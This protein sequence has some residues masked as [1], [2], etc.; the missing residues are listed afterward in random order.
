MNNYYLAGHTLK[1]FAGNF[2][3]FY[4]GIKFSIWIWRDLSLYLGWSIILRYRCALVLVQ[5]VFWYNFGF[6]SCIVVVA[7]RDALLVIQRTFWALHFLPII[8]RSYLDPVTRPSNCGTRWECASTPF[9]C[10]VHGSVLYGLAPQYLVEDCELVAAADRHQLR[11]SNTATFV[12]SRTYT[13]FGDRAFPVAGPRLWNSLPSKLRQSDLTYHQ[14]RRALKTYWFCW[15]G[16][17]I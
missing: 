12:V 4:W 8:V 2:V 6:Y 13:W 17:S 10:R 5:Y 3:V 9:R 16:L 15:L 14:F 1:K 11:S 7:Q